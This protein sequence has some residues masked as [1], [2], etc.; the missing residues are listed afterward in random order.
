MR[1][2]SNRQLDILAAENRL[3]IV[4]LFVAIA[5]F[6]SAMAYASRQIDASRQSFHRADVRAQRGDELARK[7]INDV[8]F[9]NRNQRLF[10]EWLG[11]GIIGSVEEMDWVET[12]LEVSAGTG[13]TNFHYQLDAPESVSKLRGRLLQHVS[14]SRIEILLDFEVDHGADVFRFFNE[15]DESAPGAYKLVQ[16]TTERIETGKGQLQTR[17]LVESTTDTNQIPSADRSSPESGSPDSQPKID[18]LFGGVRVKATLSWFVI[19]PAM[20][21]DERTS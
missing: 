9:L 14:V 8:S 16:L 12:L 4:V 6:V 5:M 11:S 18:P 17:E 7:H 20:Q 3:A 13:T 1:G 21:M 15:L 2:T 10:N 19:H